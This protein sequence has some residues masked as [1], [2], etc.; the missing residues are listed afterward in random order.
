MNS[1]KEEP[2]TGFV[3]VRLAL[4]LRAMEIWQRLKFTSSSFKTIFPTCLTAVI[5]E[6]LGSHGN[7]PA[8]K[9]SWKWREKIERVWHQRETSSWACPSTVCERRG[10]GPGVGGARETKVDSGKI[11]LI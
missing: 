7:Q 4:F 5:P 1:F 10:R 8:L 3:R 11:Y 9:T 6:G 2:L